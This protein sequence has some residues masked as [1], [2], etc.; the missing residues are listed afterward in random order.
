MAQLPALETRR[1][2]INNI[3]QFPSRRS[4]RDW[5]VSID[6]DAQFSSI[7]DALDVA[8]HGDT[9]RIGPGMYIESLV[10]DK[11]VHL[12]GPSDPRFEIEDMDSDDLPY[13]VIIGTGSETIL[14]NAEGGSIRDLAISRASG[15]AKSMPTS[16]LIRMPSGDLK[17]ER[18]VLSEGAHSAVTSRGGEIELVRCHIRN[19]QVGVCILNAT[20]SLDRTHIEGSD[21]LA[22][23]LENGSILSMTD[24]SFEGRTVI[25]GEVLV[26]SGNDID[27][28]FVHDTMST[29]GN[30]ITGLVH[31]CD[32]TAG[33]PVAIGI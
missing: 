2:K 14:W 3:I 17:V 30:R 21:V 18:C 27:T 11:A 32:F 23:H 22:L 7:S 6:G 5:T 29:E 19:I 15:D 24:N 33:E 8:E 9:I 28:L 1:S 4:R 31:V 25:R 13:A 12:V 26:F 10:V 20:A 16:A